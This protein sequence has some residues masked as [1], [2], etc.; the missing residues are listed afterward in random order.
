MIL[1]QPFS[2]LVT[3]VLAVCICVLINH[4][5]VLAHPLDHTNHLDLE[6]LIPA[7]E[8]DCSTYTHSV[9]L[10]DGVELE[11]VS[12]NTTIS[13]RMTSTTDD[14]FLSFG[15]A[16][17]ASGMMKDSEAIIGTTPN[18][19]I[20]YDLVP[21]FA[22]VMDDEERQK[23]LMNATF[24]QSTDTTGSILEFSKLLDDGTGN[25]VINGNGT[26][27]F[28]WAL[29]Y[30]FKVEYGHKRHGK[31]QIELAPCGTTDIIGPNVIVET[32]KDYKKIL[33]VH[34]ILA[35][36][37]FAVFMPIAAASAA[38]NSLLQFE[39]FNKKAWFVIHTSMNTLAYIFTVA[40]F[41]M[42][43][44]SVGDKTNNKGHFNFTHAIVGLVTFVLLT[45]Q[46]LFA[47]LRPSLPK[48]LPP[49]S[50]EA[51]GF[52]TERDNALSA[53][54]VS[55]KRKLW[56]I[57]H[58]AVALVIFGLG[59]FAIHTGLELY[60]KHYYGKSYKLIFWILWGVLSVLLLI[61]VAAA[62][63]RESE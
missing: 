53:I 16:N 56:N 26:N 21:E 20:L 60:Q 35:V 2:F 11:Y 41:F 38:A 43:V 61:T 63:R 6:D 17:D 30:A 28:I 27:T 46:I 33:K 57:M 50:M 3:L 39:I 49:K 23:T 42:G 1:K 32:A 54:D 55:P 34:G 52:T 15:I 19:V 22:T 5:S 9:Q 48:P 36:V 58:R 13:V 29:G 47:I 40:V 10:S 62:K 8:V 18:N 14:S 25:K 31:V 44:Y 51:D 59:L 37:A 24:V 12:T 7:D 45:L 4:A